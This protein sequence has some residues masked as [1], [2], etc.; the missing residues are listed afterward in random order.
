MVGLDN[1]GSFCDAGAGAA[2]SA[3]S[4]IRW[5]PVGRSGRLDSSGMKPR[6]LSCVAAV[7]AT[8]L[9]GLSLG[10]NGGGGDPETFVGWA[11]PRPW[12][13]EGLP[14]CQR[15]WGRSVGLSL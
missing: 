15:S 8:F 13:R 9:D 1:S 4:V 10:S 2:S 11:G 3:N 7:M 12:S 6:L 5:F 14:R